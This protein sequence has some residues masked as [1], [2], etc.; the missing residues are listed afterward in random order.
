MGDSFEDKMRVLNFRF[1]R[2]TILI[3]QNLEDVRLKGTDSKQSFWRSGMRV[4]EVC[5]QTF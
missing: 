3:L 5:D 2:C 1:Q 4:S